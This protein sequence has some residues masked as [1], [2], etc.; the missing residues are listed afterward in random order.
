MVPN[1]ASPQDHRVARWLATSGGLGD[2]LPAPG[3]TAGS[4]PAA[5]VWWVLAATLRPSWLVLAVTAALCIAAVVAGLWASDAE[6]TRRQAE[7]PGPI[8][9]DEVA[10]QWLTYL[11][12]LPF[13]GVAGGFNLVVFT[14]AGFLLFRIFDIAKPWPVRRF[15]ALPGGAGIMTDDLAAAIYS[16]AI[17]ALGWSIFPHALP[18]S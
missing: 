16:G 7:D 8:V 11:V 6:A 4:L 12:A 2:H 15:E 13:V 1:P 17:L 18:P 9:I 5:I 3:T 10:G 14:G